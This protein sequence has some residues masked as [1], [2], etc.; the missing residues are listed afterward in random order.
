MARRELLAGNWK[1]HHGPAA[2]RAFAE[3]L[4][5]LLPAEVGSE[6]AICPPAVSLSAA[7]EAFTGL[8]VAVGAQNMHAQ[9][10]GAFTGETAAGML[11][12]LGVTYVILGHSERRTLF[13]ESD[14]VVAEKTLAALKAGLAPILCVGESL[15]QREA[16]EADAVVRAQVIAG[17]RH[18]S[19]QD[20]IQ[21]GL[22]V[23]Y[24][25]IWAIGTGKTC[26]AAEAGRMGS[27]T[28]GAIAE[29]LGA[30]AAAVTRVLYGGSVKP[31][32]MGAQRE[33]PDL[34]GALVGGASLEA[35]SFA[36]LL[37]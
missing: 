29:A 30:E 26:E 33:Q 36:A 15:A 7:V 9:E 16:G 18:V 27:V 17:L 34:D 35:T 20:A 2:T 5:A 21:G 6:L 11:K 22:V 14:E 31:E 32:T 4:R 3:A 12:E 10:K 1:M 25:P 23:A 13:G 37:G 24:E 8:P 19:P 28:R